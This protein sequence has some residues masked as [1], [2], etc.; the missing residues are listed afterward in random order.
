MNYGNQSI[1]SYGGFTIGPIYDVM[2]HA[3]KT[4]EL[5]F[6]SY[7]FSWYMEKLIS[8]LIRA[9]IEFITPFAKNID[10]A[11]GRL[12][13]NT[14]RAGKY[15]DRFV[16]RSSLSPETLFEQIEAAN[17]KTMSFLV[18]L[19]YAIAAREKNGGR[20]PDR[21]R[22]GGIVSG[23]FQPRFFAVDPGEID[24]RRPVDSADRFLDTLEESFT[25]RPGKS[26]DTCH[27]CKT[28]PGVASA[29]DIEN[30]EVIRLTLC[31]FCLMKL[32]ANALPAFIPELKSRLGKSL[33]EK[34]RLH[35]P[36]IPEISARQIFELPEIRPLKEKAEEISDIFQK[37]RD[38]LNNDHRKLLKTHHKYYAVVQAD[39]DNLGKL[40]GSMSDVTELSERLFRFAETAEKRIGNFGGEPVYL[41][42]DDLLAFMPVHYNGK[43]VIDFI[44]AVSDDYSA[45]VDKGSGNTTISFGC[46]IAYH[47]FP[48]STARQRADSLL[49]EQAKKEK[50]SLA[51]CFTRHSG[52]E[53]KFT[54]K[55]G[56]PQFEKFRKIV[57]A[58][59]NGET[60]LPGG[61]H[62][63]LARFKPLLTAIP[64]EDRMK[65]FFQNNFNESVHERY[66]DGFKKVIDLL[67][68]Y[69]NL[70]GDRLDHVQT[71]LNILKFIK[72][73]TGKE[74]S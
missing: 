23:Y 7:L 40:A 52:A 1:F 38:S 34:N 4:R 2:R 57:D 22:I 48:L 46:N 63:N 3:R 50:D 65:A 5:W 74:R 21:D 32:R 54:L 47:K 15:H 29:R 26:A 64:E 42:G 25:F 20:A 28:L 60:E 30:D 35:Y 55:I 49:F 61:I 68:H 9:D 13:Q 6:G 43:T 18:D 67:N 8:E 72:F 70:D 17:D 12:A 62:Y 41:G 16:V 24:A 58:M 45:L 36:S 66:E 69:L 56:D 53:L 71:V 59:L 39:G 73:L 10:T 44:K 14:S 37:I 31:P 19:A 27:R 11:T 51:L 33:D